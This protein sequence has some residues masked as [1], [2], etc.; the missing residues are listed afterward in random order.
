MNRSRR[1]ARWKC[2]SFAP[3]CALYTPEAALFACLRLLACSSYG[4]SVGER[5]TAR[6]SVNRREF[7]VPARNRWSYVELVD[8]FLSLSLLFLSAA[9]WRN[10]GP[11]AAGLTQKNPCCGLHNPWLGDAHAGWKEK[12][13]LLRELRAKGTGGVCS[14]D[15][16]SCF[17]TF[18]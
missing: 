3:L 6:T 15:G 9:H 4:D 2:V 16:D 1:F 12:G 7:R 18:M 5:K 8:L 11:D 14:T 10:R 17:A 13:Q